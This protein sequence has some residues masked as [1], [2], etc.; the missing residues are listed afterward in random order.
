[1]ASC[2]IAEQTFSSRSVCSMNSTG[3][4]RHLLGTDLSEE[5]EK[6]QKEMEEDIA[7]SHSVECQGVF[8]NMVPNVLTVLRVGT[9]PDLT[10]TIGGSDLMTLLSEADDS[11]ATQTYLKCEYMG[12]DQT[13]NNVSVEGKKMEMFHDSETLASD[14]EKREQYRHIYG[15]N[16]IRI[17]H[18]AVKDMTK[19]LSPT[20]HLYVFEN[21]PMIITSEH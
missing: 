11:C 5:M 13:N 19:E 17:G 21:G 20:T 4:C 6:L 7:F 18:V 8:E 12:M 16:A 1:M 10:G 2:E 15:D 9:N 14:I 3:S